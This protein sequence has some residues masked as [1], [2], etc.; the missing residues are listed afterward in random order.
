MAEVIYISAKELQDLY[1]KPKLVICDIR[2]A[3]EFARE[4][5]V[6]AQN[7][8]LSKFDFNTLNSM[9]DEKIVV[10][11]CQSGNRTKMNESKLKALNC[12][13]VFILKDG[14]SE[15]KSQG[16]AVAINNKAPL[17]LMR[18]VQ[19]VA[20]FLILLGVILSFTLSAYYSLLSGFVGAG[21]MFAGITGYCG[22]ANLLMLLPYNKANNCNS[23]CNK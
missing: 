20:G 4:H 14:L 19:I 18:Q 11:H 7:T 1:Q 16:C 17:P 5:I 15:W 12:K 3:D 2:E 22:M 21:L 8:P 13:T 23:T 10:F 6:G 9:N